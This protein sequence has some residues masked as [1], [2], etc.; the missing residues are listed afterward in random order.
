MRAVLFTEF[1]ERFVH[2]K[3]VPELRTRGVDVVHVAS[4]ETCERV[5][6]V[7]VDVVLNMHEM[8]GH[9]WSQ[10]LTR[11]CSKAGVP[12]RAL[13]RKKSAWP[14]FDAAKEESMKKVV[15]FPVGPVSTVQAV[16]EPTREEMEEKL[17]AADQ[18]ATDAESLAHAYAEEVSQLKAENEKL[19][20]G[21]QGAKVAYVEA[22]APSADEEVIEATR[23]LWKKALIDRDAAGSMLVRAVLPEVK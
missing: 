10:K 20:A 9:T 6:Y 1:P 8:G 7:G 13:S 22:R 18:R 12:V 5:A 2:E 17:R 23:T 11:V 15:S 14:V 4:I 19:R 16:Q 21:L 3:I